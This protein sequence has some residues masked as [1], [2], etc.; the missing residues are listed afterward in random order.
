[1]A[2]VLFCVAGIVLYL[3]SVVL[4]VAGVVFCMAG[5]VLYVAGVVF[6]GHQACPRV[7]RGGYVK[8]P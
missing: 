2:V 6:G 3:A 7:L 8:R 4:Y 1:M 5:V